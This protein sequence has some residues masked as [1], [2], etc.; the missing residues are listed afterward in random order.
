MPDV[1]GYLLHL[2]GE[3]SSKSQA[4]TYLY[5]MGAAAVTM[6]WGEREQTL[7]PGDSAVV[8]P[9]VEMRLRQQGEYQQ[10]ELVSIKVGSLPAQVTSRVLIDTRTDTHARTHV[11]T[12]AHSLPRS[13][14][15]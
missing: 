9:F 8:K 7:A 3:H 12:P 10:A 6:A 2:R 11:R 1:G 4:F 5:N 15:L 14:G 13:L